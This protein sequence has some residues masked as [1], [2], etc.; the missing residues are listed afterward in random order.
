[1]RWVLMRFVVFA[2][3]GGGEAGTVG[4][5]G[6]A[7]EMEPRLERK[8]EALQGCLEKGDPDQR[9]LLMQAYG[10]VGRIR[11]VGAEQ[12]ADSAG[13]INGCTGWRS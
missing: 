8:R 7:E 13:I 10:E 12:R 2:A 4:V 11:M 9:S 5:M 3:V 1:M 6:R